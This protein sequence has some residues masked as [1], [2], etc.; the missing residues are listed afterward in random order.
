M[1]HT[2]THTQTHTVSQQHLPRPTREE[3]MFLPPAC[4]HDGVR[5]S[6]RCGVHPARHSNRL[7]LQTANSAQSSHYT[8]LS[9]WLPLQHTHTC[10]RVWVRASKCSPEHE[11]EKKYANTVTHVQPVCIQF[12]HKWMQVHTPCM[13]A[14]THTHTLQHV[15]TCMRTL[16][17]V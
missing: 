16:S 6:L 7:F 17:T 15:H 13:Q 4:S 9:P 2:H 14:H 11:H 5:Q 3:E 8:Y 1:T 10:A 12:V